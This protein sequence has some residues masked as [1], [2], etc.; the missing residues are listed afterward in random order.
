MSEPIINAVSLFDK[1]PILFSIA[2]SSVEDHRPIGLNG[3]S[4]EFIVPPSHRQ[5]THYDFYLRFAF[6]VTNVDDSPLPADAKVTVENNI[7]GALF[8]SFTCKLNN[9]VIQSDQTYWL[10]HYLLTLF[11]NNK[12]VKDSYLR[13]ANLWVPD[14]ADFTDGTVCKL[15]FL[16]FFL[17][18]NSG[19]FSSHK[20]RLR[21]ST[22]LNGAVSTDNYFRQN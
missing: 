19:P 7:N 13:A 8:S 6:S 22:K 16:I 21:F 12:V 10:K 4:L 1:K 2:G 9:S 14:S 18:S 15:F 20:S 11:R 5:F 17:S 3:Y